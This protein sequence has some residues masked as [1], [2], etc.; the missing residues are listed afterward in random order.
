[1][2]ILQAPNI[3]VIQLK[4]FGGIFGGKIDK[5]ISFGEILVLSNF[6]SKASKDPQPEYKLFGIIVH[7]GFSPESGHYYAY[8]KVLLCPFLIFKQLELSNYLLIS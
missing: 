6:M 3:L 8:V 2:S 7:S 1:M 4:R 5:A